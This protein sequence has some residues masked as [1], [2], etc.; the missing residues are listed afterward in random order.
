MRRRHD[1]LY[2]AAKDKKYPIR[3]REWMEGLEVPPDTVTLTDA[4]NYF[5]RSAPKRVFVSEP[6]IKL[7]HSERTGAYVFTP[8]TGRLEVM[9]ESE[10]FVRDNLEPIPELEGASFRN[11][12]KHAIVREERMNNILVDLDST[13]RVYFIL[14]EYRLR[15]VYMDL[16]LRRR[17]SDIN[18]F[19]NPNIESINTVLGLPFDFVILY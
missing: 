18:L 14:S 12:V 13:K 16:A 9:I 7:E 8:M 11:D 19:Y 3:Y 4:I 6:N 2:R 15:I 10:G 5:N 17:I 1:I